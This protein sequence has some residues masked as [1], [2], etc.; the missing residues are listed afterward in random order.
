MEK[1]KKRTLI[2]VCLLV[3][4][5]AVVVVYLG[6]KNRKYDV[7]LKLKNNYGMSWVF[8]PDVS[9][10]YYE[11]EYTGE[12]MTFGV[13]SYNLPGHP[14]WGDRW[15]SAEGNVLNDFSGSLGELKAPNG[16]GALRSICERGEYIYI[17]HALGSSDV[18][19]P[20]V[21]YLYITIK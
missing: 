2:I 21:V 1:K 16:G 18:W 17:L 5:I 14:R 7:S 19:K 3:I 15:F 10:L 4:L 8:T 13:D 11:L 9:E 12:E 20:R 6:F